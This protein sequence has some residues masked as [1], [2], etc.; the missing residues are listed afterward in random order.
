MQY[1]GGSMISRN[2]DDLVPQPP[3]LPS[4]TTLSG[5]RRLRNAAPARPGPRIL[6]VDGDPTA[7][8]PI[9]EPLEQLGYRIIYVHDG[10]QAVLLAQREVPA[11]V[12]LELI[13]PT[14]DGFAVCRALRSEKST[15][16]TPILIAS[17]RTD[18]VDRV[19]SLELGA[20][21][22]VT[23]PFSPREVLLRIRNLIKSS[24]DQEPSETIECQHLFI[25]LTRH[26]VAVGNARVELTVTEFRLLAHLARRDGLVQPRNQLFREVWDF[27]PGVN[28]RTLDT[29]IRRLRKKLGPAGLFLETVRGVGYRFF[30]KRRDS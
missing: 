11:L 14:L 4:I 7:L 17:T 29:H 6:L 26:V 19:V 27:Q 24:R 5:A 12:V 21:D 15:V 30:S 28:S 2:Q 10:E 1:R 16:H 8:R 9:V 23:K 20:D 22:Y 13:L 3:P 18:E 25:D